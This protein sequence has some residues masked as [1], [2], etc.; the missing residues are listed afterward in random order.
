MI[1]PAT[2]ARR[3]N[4]T[5]S[6][7]MPDGGAVL[8]NLENRHFYT[9]NEAAFS[10]WNSLDGSATLVDILQRIVAEYDVP[11]AKAREAVFVQVEEFL[12]EGLAEVVG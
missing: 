6:T 10:I 9:L 12:R 7:R 8:L 5:V 1:G 4:S 11:E 3:K 2:L